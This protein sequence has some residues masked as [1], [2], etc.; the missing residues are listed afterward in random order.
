[1]NYVV[2]ERYTGADCGDL[3]ADMH[4]WLDRRQIEAEEFTSSVLGR[5]IALRVGFRD[6]DD[7]AVFV[8]AFSGRLLSTDPHRATAGTTISPAE[9]DA[10]PSFSKASAP[11]DDL[12]PENVQP[13]LKAPP[14][15]VSL[16]ITQ[17]QR[18]DLR[19]RGYSDEQSGT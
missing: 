16:M 15:G 3:V 8:S 13:A 1:V 18:A 5:G 19:E 11:S 7:A 17:Q 14:A 6:E 2:E 9:K 4:S 12:P 10:G